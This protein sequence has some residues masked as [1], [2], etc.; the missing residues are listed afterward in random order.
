MSDLTLGKSTGATSDPAE[1]VMG[2][3]SVN[4]SSDVS[5]L[6]S[7]RMRKPVGRPKDED[8]LARRRQEILEAAGFFF[9]R[10]GYPN[11]DLKL[12]AE[13]LGVAKGTL[14]RY[15]PS[16]KHLFL[17]TVDNCMQQLSEQVSLATSKVES[18]QDRVAHALRA[19]FRFFDAHPYVVELIVQ[20]RAE[21]KDRPLP[22][23]LDRDNGGIWR[24][25]FKDLI[26]SGS[27]REVSEDRLVETMSSLLYGV[28][29]NKYVSGSSDT[30]ESKTED[31]L[32]IVFNGLM[33]EKNWGSQKG[34]HGSEIDSQ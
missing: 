28:I 19:Y 16:K 29:F 10:L 15:F 31:V 32:D 3:V 20:E 23:P 18:P 22:A 5:D 8:L 1:D 34:N 26:A 11:S 30:L 17:A 25:Q 21:F 14:Y 12:L 9:A 7:V 13:E 24:Q 33:K 2:A 27:M 4:G 6:I